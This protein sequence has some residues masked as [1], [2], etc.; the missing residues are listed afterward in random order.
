M[1]TIEAMASESALFF[2]LPLRIRQTI[3]SN[4]LKQTTEMFLLRTCRQIYVESH[5]LVFR[6]PL[7][8]SN[9]TL[10]QR[11]RKV[12]ERFMPEVTEIFFTLH[13]VDMTPL[14]SQTV[15]PSLVRSGNSLP[16]HTWD[17][18]DTEVESIRTALIRFQSVTRFTLQ[19]LEGSPSHLYRDFV[20]SI[21]GM[22]ASIY[23]NI[24]GLGFE[25][26]FRDQNFQLLSRFMSLESISFDCHLVQRQAEI[27]KT[28]SRLNLTGVSFITQRPP[29]RSFRH[30]DDMST[31]TSSAMGEFLSTFT[32]QALS[33]LCISQP[34]AP[35]PNVLVSLR[36]FIYKNTRVNRLELDW[37]R[38]DPEI[39]QRYTLL[40]KPLKCLWIRAVDRASAFDIFRIIDEEKGDQRVVNLQDVGIL[41]SFWHP[42][43]T[44]TKKQTRVSDSSR[45]EVSDRVTFKDIHQDEDL[46]SAELDEA[47]LVFAQHRLRALGVRVMWCTD[48]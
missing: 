42:I 13:D 22:L 16:L 26:S 38:L 9:Q 45:A 29:P 23:P 15:S 8:L 24:N 34:H 46:T 30:Q 11:L 3:Y 37:P 7:K 28:F 14:L 21:I 10:R 18:Y 25:G 19:V 36:S 35:T 41:R 2:R 48:P 20:G 40:N 43:V 47:N 12:P 17:I 33:S 6:Q 31:P 4:V 39:L 32:S 1:Q 5:Q 44:E 27:A